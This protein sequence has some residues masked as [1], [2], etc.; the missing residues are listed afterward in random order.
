[1][2]H[3]QHLNEVARAALDINEHSPLAELGK[4]ACIVAGVNPNQP[5]FIFG[6]GISAWRAKIVEA[7]LLKDINLLTELNQ[8]D[9]VG[10]LT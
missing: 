1:M 8:S 10:T 9:Y 4:A 3:I 7:Q 2:N 6:L 5:V